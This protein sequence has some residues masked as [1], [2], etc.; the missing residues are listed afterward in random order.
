MNLVRPFQ[1]RRLEPDH[2]V[3]SATIEAREPH[4]VKTLPLF[5]PGGIERNH[6]VGVK[7]VVAER[8]DR[9]YG[10][11]DPGVETPTI[12]MIPVTW[13]S[14]M[15]RTDLRVLASPHPGVVF[16]SR[17]TPSASATRLM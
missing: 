5:Y 14:V 13:P 9:I 7:A 2:L 3:A 12:V 10:V 16:Y 6:A 1:G 11:S 4:D 8:D 17:P 15:V